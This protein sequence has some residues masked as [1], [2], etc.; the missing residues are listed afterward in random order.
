V[1]IRWTPTQNKDLRGARPTLTITTLNT[2]ADSITPYQ[3]Y[4]NKFRVTGD[5]IIC[6]ASCGGVCT[7]Q[8]PEESVA[9]SEADSSTHE[10]VERLQWQ[11]EESSDHG[12]EASESFAS[13]HVKKI[14]TSSNKSGKG[15]NKPSEQNQCDLCN[16]YEA[17]LPAELHLNAEVFGN[18]SIYGKTMLYLYKT[19]LHG[20]LDGTDA[21]LVVAERTRFDSPV[22]IHYYGTIIGCEFM[23]GASTSGCSLWD[24]ECISVTLQGFFTTNFKGPFSG[25]SP[26]VEESCL[27]QVDATTNYYVKK[28][29]VTVTNAMVEVLADITP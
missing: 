21:D 10:P 19:R 22:F 12:A 4:S 18:L 5:I 6:N 9:Y 27:F 29:N 2:I 20:A 7:V 8:A 14:L 28:N 13:Y 3:S 23:L 16:V 26:D 1:N 11:Y 17:C 24:P 25:A 15:S